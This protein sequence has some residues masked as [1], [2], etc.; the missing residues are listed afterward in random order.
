MIESRIHQ[1]WL[2]GEPPNRVRKLSQSI[3]SALNPDQYFFWTDDKVGDFEVVSS[4]LYKSCNN[5]GLRTD[6]LRFEIIYKFGGV[7]L[8]CDFYG[9]SPINSFLQS[10]DA[11]CFF[12]KEDRFYFGREEMQNCVFGANQFNPTIEFV[13]RELLKTSESVT[14]RSPNSATIKDVFSLTGPDKIELM[15]RSLD[16]RFVSSDFFCSYPSLFRGL[17]L[18]DALTFASPKAVALHLWDLSWI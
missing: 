18:S 7:Y 6:L 11:K 3:K 4:E 8:D 9:I 15:L 2:G 16:V 12:T 14:F 1:I 17:P 10:L 5:L 13:F